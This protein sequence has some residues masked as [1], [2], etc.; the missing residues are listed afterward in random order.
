V[1]S[2]PK[3]F[4]TFLKD[5]G[6]SKGSVR[7]YV[8]DLGRFTAWFT[9]EYGHEF[10]SEKLN[11][12]V[13]DKFVGYLSENQIP[14]ATAKRYVASLKQFAKWISS[15]KFPTD[16]VPVSASSVG[17]DTRDGMSKVF[18]YRLAIGKG[19]TEYL[20]GQGLSK[21]SIRNYAA[22]LGRFLSWFEGKAKSRLSRPTF[23]QNFC[24]C[25]GRMFYPWE[26]PRRR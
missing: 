24:P 2:L 15:E 20:A 13:L 6:L 26:F 1:S 22:D 9:S 25:T 19:Y 3:L 5:Q 23:R 17:T 18:H 7:N 14:Q 4:A 16:G 10:S 12:K 21:G 11:D 8:A